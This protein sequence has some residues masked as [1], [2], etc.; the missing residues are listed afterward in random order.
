MSAIVYMDIIEDAVSE[1]LSAQSLASKDESLQTVMDRSALPGGTHVKVERRAQPAAEAAQLV[2]DLRPHTA[3]LAT[4][5]Q[6]AIPGSRVEAEVRLASEPEGAGQGASLLVETRKEAA[7]LLQLL[8]RSNES[9]IVESGTTATMAGALLAPDGGG[10][11]LAV[12][13]LPGSAA[14]EVNV[15]TSVIAG[16]AEGLAPG[17]E[18]AMV[19]G[20]PHEVSDFGSDAEGISVQV[21]AAMVIEISTLAGRG[22]NVS[23]LDTPIEFS[24]PAPYA[25]GLTC[26]FWNEERAEWSTE[27][28][29]VDES[30]ALGDPIKCATWHLSLF[31]A[32]FIGIAETFACSQFNLLNA[33]SVSRVWKDDWLRSPGS[34]LF[35]SLLLIMAFAFAAAAILDRKRSKAQ[36]WSVEYF[37]IPL[38]AN[39]ELGPTPEEDEY[40]SFEENGTPS[41]GTMSGTMSGTV[42]RLT[43]Y[44]SPTNAEEVVGDVF[45]DVAE[46]QEVKNFRE[47]GIIIGVALS[48]GVCC[49]AIFQCCKESALRDAVDEVAS[50]YFEQF[51]DLRNCLEGIWQGL[52]F[53]SF[54]ARRVFQMSQKVMSQLVLTSSRHLVGATL[55]LNKDVVTF[56]LEDK[57]LLEVL[58]QREDKLRRRR[59]REMRLSGARFTSEDSFAPADPPA[60]AIGAAPVAR[61]SCRSRDSFRDYCRGTWSKVQNREDAWSALHHEIYGAM[62]DHVSKTSWCSV[63]IMVCRIFLANNPVGSIY[64]MSIFRSCKM[65]ALFRMM[66][67]VG[68][69]MVVCIF[70]SAS[71]RVKGK[72]GAGEVEPSECGSAEDF[73]EQITY[74]LGRI[75]SIAMGS[76]ILA[77]MPVNLLHSLHTRRFKKFPYEKCREWKKQLRAWRM[78][79]RV[80]WVLAFMYL[81]FGIFF[82]ALFLANISTDDHEDW[83]QA[84][85]LSLL[86][87]TFILPF[88]IAMCMPTLAATFVTAVST[89][90]KVERSTL[91][92]DVRTSVRDKRS[93]RY[94]IPAQAV[95]I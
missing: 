74:K 38:G 29:I 49:T 22:I 44:V 67:L 82:I 48:I 81:T 17:E 80:I 59:S 56:V 12:P 84:G 32:I 21:A 88:A 50:E 62:D 16:L 64:T 39:P 30:S 66:E 46:Q 18:L 24:M 31:G 76:V 71:G 45:L 68:D 37:L 47:H 79:D 90:G 40:S 33:E 1:A 93:T 91:I 20:V 51:S 89:L 77:G 7:T 73:K 63:P 23:G 15:P 83:Y 70:Y 34:I 5:V 27:G 43:S 57:D 11:R 10:A 58:A 42:A 85:G 26:A 41:A 95:D 9:S 61:D 69:L 54:G 35:F 60:L 28:V 36:R 78:Q 19:A 75:L 92:S 94:S 86:L 6:A 87:D 65:R 72:P 8:A 13:G 52:E 4:A 14:L 2:Q 55:G 3:A 25:D 53:S